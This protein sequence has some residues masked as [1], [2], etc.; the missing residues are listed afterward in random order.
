MSLTVPEVAKRLRK[1]PETVRRWIREGK[2]A[3][4]K[5]GNQHFVEENEVAALEVDGDSLPT[6][7]NRTFWGGPSPDWVRLVREDRESH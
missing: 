5:I 1:N 7:F 3:A 4:Q 6:R 2:L